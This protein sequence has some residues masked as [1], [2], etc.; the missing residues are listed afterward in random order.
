MA[1]SVDLLTP[2]DFHSRK[3][4][5]EIQLHSRGLY[6][7][8]MDTEDEPGTAIDK[9]R[10]LNK[11]DEAFG[12]LCLSPPG[13]FFSILQYWRLR[14]KYG[15]NWKPYMESRM[16]WEFTILKMNWCLSILPILRPWIIFSQSSST[17][18]YSWSNAKWRRRW[19]AHPHHTLHTWSWLFSFYLYI[20]C[21][22]AHNPWMEDAY[23]Q[24]LHWVPNKWTW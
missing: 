17:L 15:T 2:Y 9:S 11:K 12:F 3:G 23:T 10:F 19:S 7:V 21:G 6:R 13:I 16:I 14:K 20:P 18:S 5:M 1:S 24:C 8:T 22:E 4:D